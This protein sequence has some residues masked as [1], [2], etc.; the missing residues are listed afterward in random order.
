MTFLFVS[1]ETILSVSGL[2]RV[3]RRTERA[4]GEIREASEGEVSS[5]STIVALMLARRE[6]ES[7]AGRRRREFVTQEEQRGRRRRG[8]RTRSGKW[9][10]ACMGDGA[11][12]LWA[13]VG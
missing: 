5:M 9:E 1:A 3:G 2:F 7:G 8:R 12:Q 13:A 11:M 6:V 4:M 10:E